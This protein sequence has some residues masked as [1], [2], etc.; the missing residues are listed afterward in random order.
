MTPKTF[1]DIALETADT[2]VL[3]DKAYGSSFNKTAEF[4][5]LLFPDG[6]VDDQYSHLMYIVRVLDKIGRIANCSLLPPEEGVLDAY[7]DINGY[8]TL[9]LKKLYDE[10]EDAKL[11]EEETIIVTHEDTNNTR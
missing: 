5:K 1:Q 8:T 9:M 3:K 2:L 4:L 6:V 7:K 11:K 10:S